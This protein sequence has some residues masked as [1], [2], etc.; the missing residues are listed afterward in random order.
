M[1]AQYF[2]SNTPNEQQIIKCN[3]LTV[4]GS[5]VANESVAVAKGISLN[6]DLSFEDNSDPAVSGTIR[7]PAMTVYT[8]LTSETTAVAITGAEQQFIVDTF[9]TASIP[10]GTAVSFAINNASIE[11]NKTIV[12]CNKMGSTSALTEVVDFV[13]ITAAGGMTLTRYNFGSG[14]APGLQR[15]CFKLIQTA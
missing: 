9:N 10:A 2:Q 15:L 12:V 13:S 7:F 6:G 4:R 14:A 8:Q 11:L 5:V 1:S 3:D